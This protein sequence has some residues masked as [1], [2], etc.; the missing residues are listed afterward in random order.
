M[1]LI[2][3]MGVTLA[4]KCL[5]NANTAGAIG[6]NDLFTAMEDWRSVVMTKHFR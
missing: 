1:V 2:Q 6:G 4:P 5:R 3:R